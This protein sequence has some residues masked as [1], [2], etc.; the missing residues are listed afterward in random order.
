V[1]VLLLL[2]VLVLLATFVPPGTRGPVEP[3]P[4]V[5]QVRFSPVA[6]DDSDPGRRRLGRLA[7][8]GGWRL[9]SNNRRFGGISAM[10]VEAGEVTAFSDSG[11]LFRFA[12]PRR[13]DV[14]RARIGPL[15]AGPGG[16]ERKSDRDIESA[17][18]GGGS[19]W[20]GFERSNAV[21]RYALPGWRVTQWAAPPAMRR[22]PANRGAEAMVA[23]ADGRFILFA[24]GKGSS[25]ASEALLFDGDPSRPGT[26]AV[27][28]RYAKPRGYRTTDAA[29]L[30][31]GRILVHN[32]RVAFLEGV[33]AKLSLV[34]ISRA[35]A[36]AVLRGVELADFHRPINVDNMEAL[37]VTREGRRT[38]V[39]IASDDNYSPLQQT[40]LLKFALDDE[41]VPR[42]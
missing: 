3:L 12:L 10:H 8:L 22:W 35:G 30:P 32:R 1:R 42:R 36:G 31:D 40:L 39:W 23:L 16:K 13:G 19:A 4:R 37:S 33:S 27:R 15:P 7:W 6:I 29:L 24:E 9:T 34:D 25:A 21:W 11:W 20:L 14:S 17:F 38:I 41:A 2:L 5:S 26:R 18:V 28:M